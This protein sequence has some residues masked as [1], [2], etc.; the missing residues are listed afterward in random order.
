MINPCMMLFHL[1]LLNVFISASVGDS[2]SSQ[3]Q[4]FC[5]RSPSRSPFV[6]ISGIVRTWMEAGLAT[7]NKVIRHVSES[8]V[9]ESC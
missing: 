6:G 9:K 2:I 3:K 1:T 5:K 7:E 4:P 8:S